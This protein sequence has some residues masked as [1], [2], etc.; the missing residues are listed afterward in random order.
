MKIDSGTI[1]LISLD[2]TVGHE[3][4]GVRP[5]IVV[6]DPEVSDDQRFPVMCVIP[7]TRTA[8]EGAL[9]PRLSPGPSGLR[10]PSFAM[11]D[12]LRAIDKRRVRKS[13]GR[14]ESAEL[15]TI[16][17]AIRLFLGLSK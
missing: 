16:D 8:G 1:V 5:C 7:I 2:P 9:Y 6:S 15:A 4:R 13:F 14:I 10:E 12:Q 11:V 17:D 3:Q